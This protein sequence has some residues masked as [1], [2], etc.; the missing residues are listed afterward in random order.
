MT[1]RVSTTN[2]GQNRCEP[3]DKSEPRRQKHSRGLSAHQSQSKGTTWKTYH[4]EPKSDYEQCQI[5]CL[6]REWRTKRRLARK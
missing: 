5:T 3:H 6:K 4:E 2:P 1:I